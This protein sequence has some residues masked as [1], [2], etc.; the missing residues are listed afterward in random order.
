MDRRF[1]IRKAVPEDLDI[2]MDIMQKTVDHMQRPEW[3]VAESREY[4]SGHLAGERGFVLAA[5]DEAGQMAAFF[6]VDYP[7]G[8]EDNLGLDLEFQKSE[9]MRVAH[10]DT[11]AVLPEY[12]GHGLMAGLL[13][14]AE[15]E[16]EQTSYEHLMATVHPDNRFSLDNMLGHGYRVMLTKKKYGG[17][18]RHILYKK[19]GIPTILVSACLLGVHCRYNGKGVMEEALRPFAQRAALIPVCPEI[20]GGLATP[21]DPAEQSAGRVITNTGI[22]VT[23]QYQKG[24]EETLRLAQLY[25]C[26][27]AV[28]KERSPSCGSGWIYDGTHSG[29]LVEGDGIAAGLLKKHGFPVIGESRA[30]EVKDFIDDCRKV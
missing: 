21:R 30:G 7:E 19:R 27:C 10:M 22:D 25:G 13:E 12:R 5:E 15:R 6:L 23:A 2:L 3:F 9:L 29:R 17:V 18:L 4:V 28:L 20:L 11:V 16:L 14:A 26:R 1:T 24:A 8:R